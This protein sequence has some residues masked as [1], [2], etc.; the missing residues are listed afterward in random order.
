MSD[1]K[2]A[3]QSIGC[4]AGVSPTSGISSIG[5]SSTSGAGSGVTGVSSTGAGSG[6]TSASGCCFTIAFLN[7]LIDD[8]PLLVTP[9]SSTYVYTIVS[10]A[11]SC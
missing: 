1:S 9:F 4:G 7:S 10:D 11:S 8:V 5:V 2:S 6:V 3:S